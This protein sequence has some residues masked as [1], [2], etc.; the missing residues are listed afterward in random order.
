MKVAALICVPLGHRWHPVESDTPY[1]LL[2]CD[3]CGRL[4][5]MTAES[6]GPEGWMA[7]GARSGAMGQMMDDPDRRR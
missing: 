3:R 1:P 6:R 5:E 2:K 7:R 4:R